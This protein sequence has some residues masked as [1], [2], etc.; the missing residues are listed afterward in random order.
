MPFHPQGC[1]LGPS[2]SPLS[3]T[4]FITLSG[5]PST[6]NQ[7]IYEYYVGKSKAALSPA[8]S[9]CD[10]APW[11][12]GEG[13]PWGSFPEASAG[14]TE[15]MASPLLDCSMPLAATISE[16]SGAEVSAKLS[17][18]EG[19]IPVPVIALSLLPSPV[20]L[21][22]QRNWLGVET[23]GRGLQ[24]PF[25]RG[26]L[27]RHLLVSVGTWQRFRFRHGGTHFACGFNLNSQG[28]EAEVSANISLNHLL[29]EGDSAQD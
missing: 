15:H 12:R 19:H 8:S 5:G 24:L 21:A 4:T 14:L 25:H 6:I 29:I 23:R 26:W 27:D 1:L 28:Q 11:L 17:T 9:R 7:N 2:F 20:P 16:C 10:L 18:K 3:G 22:D 13:Q